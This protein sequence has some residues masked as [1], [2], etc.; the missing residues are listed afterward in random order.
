[1]NVKRHRLGKISSG[2]LAPGPAIL[3]YFGLRKLKKGL[4][5]LA[6]GEKRD[7]LAELH[8]DP[9][10]EIYQSGRPPRDK[11]PMKML[12]MDYVTAKLAGRIKMPKGRGKQI[13][14]NGDTLSIYD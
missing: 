9:K 6:L 14:L 2:K 10:P 5:V 12:H 7:I 3:S 11:D 4:F 8:K 13:R 1:M